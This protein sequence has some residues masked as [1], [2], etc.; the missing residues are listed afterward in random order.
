[1]IRV[2]HFLAALDNGGVECLL[3]NYYR[4]IDRSNIQFDFAVNEQPDYETVGLC[5]KELRAMGCNIFVLPRFR[6][7]VKVFCESRRIMKK[8][9]YDIIHVHHTSQSFVQLFAALTCGQKIRIVHSHDYSIITTS[10]QKIKS[11][12]FNYLSKKLSTHRFA[13]SDVAGEF[14]YG[15]VKSD[16]NYYKMVNGIDYK[17]FLYN[18]NSR[19]L[20]RDKLGIEDDTILIGNIGRFTEQKNHDFLLT[21]FSDFLKKNKKSK[22]LLIGDGEL[23]NK[24]QGKIEKLSLQDKVLII[25]RTNQIPEYLCAMDCFVLPSLH[26]GLGIVLVEAQYNGLGV[27]C[28]DRVPKEVCFRR[29]SFTFLSLDSPI[30][31]WTTAINLNCRS[32]REINDNV[33]DVNK[34]NL[35]ANAKDLTA[36][37]TKIINNKKVW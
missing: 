18:A 17:R 7:V 31:S 21:V 36:V 14:M 1:M 6:N 23:I 19:E 12:I 9:K 34:F 5:G 24:A 8:G 33:E 25:N 11:F 2:L 4:K 16:R 10:T 37:Y 30:V 3:L 22:L 28:S 27:V 32:D 29:D 35:D 20:F 13:C 15:N 26:E